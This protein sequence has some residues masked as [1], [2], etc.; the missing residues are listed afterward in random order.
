MH[1]DDEG[2]L[3]RDILSQDCKNFS[4]DLRNR[5]FHFERQFDTCDIEDYVIKV[6]ILLILNDKIPRNGGQ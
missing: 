2:R 5:M 6:S 1:S 4:F 3:I